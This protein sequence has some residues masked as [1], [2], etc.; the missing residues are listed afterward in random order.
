MANCITVIYQK[1]K[2]GRTTATT[3]VYETDRRKAAPSELSSKL[4]GAW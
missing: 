1:D 4:Y 2:T 3:A